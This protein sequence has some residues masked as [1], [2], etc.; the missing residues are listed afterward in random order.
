M[1]YSQFSKTKPKPKIKFTQPTRTKLSFQGEC[2]INSIVKKYNQTGTLSHVIRQD[3]KYGD[4]TDVKSFSEALEVVRFAQEQFDLLP[5]ETRDRF[6]NDPK[7][8]LK[9]AE[10]PKNRSK[11]IDLGLVAEEPQKTQIDPKEP[12]EGSKTK[13]QKGVEN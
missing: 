10:D 2:D 8:F 13:P 7:V 1:F 9:F 4:F 11:M 12:V 5:A 3:P 6:F